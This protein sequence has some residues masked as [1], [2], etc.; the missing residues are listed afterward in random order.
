MQFLALPSVCEIAP[1]FSKC[2][3]IFFPSH[4]HSNF[5]FLVICDINEFV[6]VLLHTVTTGGFMKTFRQK[7]ALLIPK[8]KKYDNT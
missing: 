6:Y 7:T 5:S 1:F 3:N 4:Q 8:D 2:I